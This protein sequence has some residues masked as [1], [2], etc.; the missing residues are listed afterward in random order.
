MLIKDPVFLQLDTDEETGQQPDASAVEHSRNML[1][2]EES[3]V[4][5]R[6]ARDAK[7]AKMGGVD[8]FSAASQ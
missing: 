5:P 4:E 3:R 6:E 7:E 2:V 8:P 1:V